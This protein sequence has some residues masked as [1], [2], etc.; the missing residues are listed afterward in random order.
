LQ[1]ALTYEGKPFSHEQL[2]PEDG[3]IHIKRQCRPVRPGQE[4]IDVMNV[5]LGSEQR[6]TDR[7][8]RMSAALGNLDRKKIDFAKWK[9]RLGERLPRGIRMG[10]HETHQSR[11]G[12]FLDGQSSNGMIAGFKR[13]EKSLK[14]A[15]AVLE[16]DGELSHA[17]QIEAGAMF[18]LWRK[19]AFHECELTSGRD[20]I[21]I[22]GKGLAGEA[23]P[24]FLLCITLIDQPT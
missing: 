11:I 17:R 23:S 22:K 9:S 19:H 10:A 5:Y 14:P 20:G 24:E 21:L 4:W 7:N 13:A 6:R 16:K 2:C 3:I 15:D 18:G 1:I 12:R 8:Q